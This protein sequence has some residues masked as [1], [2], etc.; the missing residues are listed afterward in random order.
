MHVE[1]PSFRQ[2]GSVCAA[3]WLPP[4]FVYSSRSR[5]LPSPMYG[6]YTLLFGQ[7]WWR[8]TCT[9]FVVS[10]W[11]VSPTPVGGWC[12]L[13]MSSREP[14]IL[15]GGY[16][17]DL[18]AV[19][20]PHKETAIPHIVKKG[21]RW[22]VNSSFVVHIHKKERLL[23]RQSRVIS[24]VQQSSALTSGCGDH[25]AAMILLL[26]PPPPPE[27]LPQLFRRPFQK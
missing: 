7:L 20:V 17:D 24:A 3:A 5:R 16:V 4:G 12:F 21:L 6:R 19:Y 14:A 1:S 2:S 13:Y 22:L 8:A 18:L 23:R 25:G 15:R 10:M 9:F 11:S 27:N 26:L